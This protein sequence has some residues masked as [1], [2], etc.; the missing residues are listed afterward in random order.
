MEEICLLLLLLLVLVCK[1]DL[2]DNPVVMGAIILFI[3]SLFYF[4]VTS[5]KAGIKYYSS[6]LGS[7][8][9]QEAGYVM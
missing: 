7:T 8:F 1:C 2:S 4:F 9:G 5:E 3:Y 6:C